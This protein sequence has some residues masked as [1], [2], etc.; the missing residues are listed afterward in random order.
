MFVTPKQ[1]KELENIA[2][3]SGVSFSEMMDNAGKQLAELIQ[4]YPDRKELPVLFLAGN[5]NNGGDCYVAAMYLKQAGWNPMV[6]MPLGEPRTDIAWN[7]KIAAVAAGV[8]VY[9]DAGALFEFAGT[10]V[11]GLFGTGFRDALP[12][13]IISLLAHCKP[14]QLK[15]ACDIPSGGNG[16][17]GTVDAGTIHADVTLTFAVKK[18][19]LVTYPLCEYCG[20]IKVADIGIPEEA[21]SRLSTSP[22]DELTLDMVRSLLPSRK[23]DSYK[24]Q[25]GHLLNITGSTRM[26]GACVLSAES[27]YRCGAGMLTVASVEAALL[28]LTVR[29]PEAMCLPM[30]TDAD[31]FFL[32]EENHASLE[33][34]LNGKDA[35]LIGCG[36]GVTENTAALTKFVF[37]VSDCPVIVDADGL[38]VLA[39]CIECVPGGRTILTPHPA[40][41]ARLLG[42]TV[43]DVQADRPG[44]AESLAKKTGAIVILKG[45]GTI[46]SDGERSALCQLG[47]AGMARAGSGDVLAGMTASLAAQGLS[48]YDAACAAVTLHAAAG[49]CT[50]EMLPQR[51]MLPQDMILALQD[52]L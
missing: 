30:Q 10:I 51:F 35:V 1:M 26:R 48:L 44:S 37:E 47:N 6:L 22:V 40:E 46:I 41:A 2:A 50:A 32:N 12:A 31:G 17:T 43:A 33:A 3:L 52:V 18:L 15:I 49:D 20:E 21:Y 36:M 16:A 4:S 11:D 9:A 19:G 25:H 42:C 34:A 27:A 23:A 38:N 28:P 7:A 8:Q 24:N 5:G 29:L 13:E 45:A 14:D 39:D